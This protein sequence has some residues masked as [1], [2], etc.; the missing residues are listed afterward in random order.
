MNQ[1]E[2]TYIVNKVTD[3]QLTING[4][5][6][7]ELWKKANLLTDFCYPWDKKIAPKTEFKALWDNHN[8]YFVFE[9][10][11]KEIIL[12]LFNNIKGNHLIALFLYK[13]IYIYS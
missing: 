3:N 6:N 4:K 5:G 1:N 11:D 7:S 10:I 8:L 13:M 12:K 2:K 9:T